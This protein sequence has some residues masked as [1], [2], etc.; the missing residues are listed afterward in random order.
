[1]SNTYVN[2]I[3]RNILPIPWV[4][5]AYN[6]QPVHQ[7]GCSNPLEGTTSN[8][9]TQQLL[10]MGT[11]QFID[12]TTHRHGFWRQFIDTIEDNTSTL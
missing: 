3:H 12:K 9:Q 5:I 2:S 8:K 10:I 4:T 7:P 11:R 6:I 1:M